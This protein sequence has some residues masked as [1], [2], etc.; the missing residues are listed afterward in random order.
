VIELAS[1]PPANAFVASQAEATAQ[2]RYPLRLSLCGSCGHLQLIDVVDPVMLFADYVYVSG[3]SPSFVSHFDTYAA[4]IC[5]RI[6]LAPGDLVVDIGSNDGTLLQ[7]FKKW[8]CRVLG[9]DPAKKIAEAANA[10]G[11]E[12]I[13]AF[14]DETLAAELRETHGPAKAI[15]ANNVFAHVDDLEEL[16]RGIRSLLAEDGSFVFEVSYLV[17]VYQ[18]TLFDTIYHEHL[19]YHRVG[20]LRQFFDR[21][22]MTLY[23]AERVTTHGG[24]LR[25]Y[26]GIGN[27]ESRRTVDELEFL[28]NSLGLGSAET[29]RI[30]DSNI[31]QRGEELQSL[32]QG[33][34]SRSYRVCGYGAPAKATT[35][36]H[37]FGLDRELIGA[38][39]DDSPWKQNLFT[40]GLGIPVCAADHLVADT[41]D[42]LLVLAWNFAEPII[43]KND[44]FA[45]QGGRFIVPLPTLTVRA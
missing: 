39:I 24:S 26:A 32:L 40:P 37:H 6:D 10:A 18:Q 12:T 5:K 2:E 44:I 4:E 13:N 21:F 35:L 1:T 22:G 14:F 15:T 33:L 27:I 29:Y 42:Y 20:P 28:E 41:P 23:D 31:G 30:F 25:G 11:I 43:A 7:A 45:E 3:T 19:D 36:M 38:V 16:T 9:I 34:V 17:D 8:G